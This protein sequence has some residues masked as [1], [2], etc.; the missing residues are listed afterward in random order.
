MLS[1]SYTFKRWM[2]FVSRKKIFLSGAGLCSKW[3]AKKSAPP[4]PF[5]PKSAQ[6]GISPRYCFL[7][8]YYYFS[9]IEYFCNKDS[10]LG[11]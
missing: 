3:V 2:L 9:F 5:T 6:R 10:S 7:D 8:Y 1:T 4:N 11:S